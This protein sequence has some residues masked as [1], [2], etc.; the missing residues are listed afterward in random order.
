MTRAAGSPRFGPGDRVRVLRDNLLGNPRTPRYARGRTG[1]VAACHGE[2]VNPLDHRGVYPPLY[3]VVLGV[4][5]LF[6]ADSRDQVAVDLHED[7]LE[8]ADGR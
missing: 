7:W 2:I 1:V 5:E 4:A 8:P 6:G 3:T